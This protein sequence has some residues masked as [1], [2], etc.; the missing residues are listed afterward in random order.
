M[1]D[2]DYL[3]YEWIDKGLYKRIGIFLWEKEG[4]GQRYALSYKDS[5]QACFDRTAGGRNGY[6]F[7]RCG[8]SHWI[9][10]QCQCIGP[11]SGGCDSYIAL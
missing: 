9:A 11:Q 3:I 8:C 1:Y 10:I 2:M 4:N 6:D 7:D 5:I